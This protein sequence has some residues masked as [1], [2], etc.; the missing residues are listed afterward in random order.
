MKKATFP[1]FILL[2]AAIPVSL[3]GCTPSEDVAQTSLTMEEHPLEGMPQSDPYVFTPQEGSQEEILQV[4]EADRSLLFPDPF[5]PIDGKPAISSTLDGEALVAVQTFI[6][7]ASDSYVQVMLDGA[8]I[9]RITTGPASPINNLCGLW[10]YDNH[11]A[12]ET[13]L[14]NPEGNDTLT[15]FALGQITIDGVLQNELNGYDDAFSLQT[16]AGKP[17]FFFKRDGRI[18]YSYDGQETL[19]EYEE[20]PHYYCCSD[21]VL[22]PIQAQNMVAFF[23][24]SGDTWYYVEIGVFS[25]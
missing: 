17:F 15:P 5:T 1:I 22:N 21:S 23:A 2:L 11:W 4:H 16:I 7:N 20:V 6:D 3:I 25:E 10:I 19:L 9:Y 8:E 18:G 13:V 14:I 12:L 24:R